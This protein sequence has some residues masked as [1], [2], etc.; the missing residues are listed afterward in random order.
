MLDGA[1]REFADV[2][3]DGVE[4]LGRH[5]K[6]GPEEV[7]DGAGVGVVDHLADDAVGAEARDIGIRRLVE[8]LREDMAHGGVVGSDDFFDDAGQ[9]VCGLRHFVNHDAEV[10]GTAGGGMVH[11]EQHGGDHEAQGFFRRIGEKR[12]IAGFGLAAAGGHGVTQDGEVEAGFIPEM[13]VDGGDVGSGA[14]ADVADGGGL[15]AVFGE[16]LAGCIDEAGAGG[17][18]IVDGCGL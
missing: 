15:E 13:V 14:S 4:A 17:V 10:T 6:I 11:A 9:S 5:F 16:D 1:E 8:Q 12:G 3:G 18:V 2:C 7:D